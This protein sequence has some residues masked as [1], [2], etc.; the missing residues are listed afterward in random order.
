MQ[1]QDRSTLYF[2]VFF[3]RRGHKA[4]ATGWAW[5]KSFISF[6]VTGCFQYWI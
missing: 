6:H 2:F 4:G 1:T 3:S 5:V